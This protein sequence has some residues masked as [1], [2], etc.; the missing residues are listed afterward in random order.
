[1]Q[2]RSV[3]TLTARQLERLR[4]LSDWQLQQMGYDP[5]EV[6]NACRS[7]DEWFDKLR[8]ENWKLGAR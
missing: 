4:M 6:T 2:N 7:L 8:Y 3:L 5:I 1:M